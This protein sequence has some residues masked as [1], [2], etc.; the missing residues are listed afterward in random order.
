MP[1]THF[2]VRV[3]IVVV[4][5]CNEDITQ[6]PIVGSKAFNRSSAFFFERPDVGQSSD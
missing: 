4:S 3:S 6:Q 5:I 1:N 2:F